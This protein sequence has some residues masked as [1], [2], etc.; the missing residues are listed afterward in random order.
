LL[1][2][3]ALVWFLHVEI[4]AAPIMILLHIIPTLGGGGAERQLRMLAAEQVSRGHSVHLAVRRTAIY[5]DEMRECGVQIHQLGDL[6]SVNPKLL[7]AITRVIRR[8][9]PAIVQTWLPQMD[10]LGG[11]AALSTGTRWIISERTS[12]KY[13]SE[14]PVF[15][16]LRL[17]LGR[18]ASSVVANSSGGEQYWRTSARRELRLV[19]IPNALDIAG[20]RAASLGMTRDVNEG[21]LLLVVGRFTNGKALEIIVRAIGKL[22]QRQ[23]SPI[24]ILMMGDGSERSSIP[25]EI[26]EASLQDRIKLLPYQPD[27][28]KWLGVADG[29]ISMSRYEG[30]PNV[31]LEA[32]AGGCPVVLSDIAAHREIA[33]ASSALF[34]AVDDVNALSAA[35]DHLVVDKGGA[36]QRAGRATERV[37]SMTVTTMADAYD[38]VY[39][40]ALNGRA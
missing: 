22:S 36:L 14:I 30:N 37:A 12:A 10:F 29:L 2:H 1:D 19:T 40:E 28:W 39:N 21:A 3:A 9:K 18:F 31:V 17:L 26:E 34:V 23:T 25:R 38:A 8:I 35:I 5:E 33:D 7:L 11:I 20:I 15:A 32:M 13:Y 6:R 4:T 16:R 24:N 27:W